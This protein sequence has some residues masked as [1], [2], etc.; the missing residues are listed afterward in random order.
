[1]NFTHA[2]SLALLVQIK[3]YVKPSYSLPM[4]NSRQESEKTGYSGSVDPET[5][6]N[7][8]MSHQPFD[9]EVISASRLHSKEYI[10][11]NICA[12]LCI[13]ILMTIITVNLWL[14]KLMQFV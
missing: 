4:K 12:C 1:M 11:Q 13:I 5:L 3:R 8:Y 6:L 2:E 10:D 7:Y 14:E 9:V